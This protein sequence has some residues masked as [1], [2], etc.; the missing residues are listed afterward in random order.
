[1][2]TGESM[3]TCGGE[4]VFMQIFTIGFT[5]K[6]AERFFGL[7]EDAEVERLLDVRLRNRSQLAGFAKRDDL[8]FFLDQLLDIDYEHSEV[9]APTEELLNAWRDDE[10]VWQTYEDRFWELL[11]QR[12]VETELDS[13]SFEKPTVL[14]CSE[15]EPDHCHRR[16]VAEY[17]DEEWGGVDITHLT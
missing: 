2:I 16:I 1:M 14:L 11:N 13:G 17:L 7:L 5:K 4:N 8:R 12:A 9:L 6:G 10:I 15:H 3:I